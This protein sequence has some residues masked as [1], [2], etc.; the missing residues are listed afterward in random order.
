MTMRTA[1]AG[2]LVSLLAVSAA[3]AKPD[4]HAQARCIAAYE[5]AAGLLEADADAASGADKI[6]IRKRISKLD[7]NR[8][9]LSLA[10]ATRTDLTP[11]DSKASQ[12]ERKAEEARLDA[13]TP[14]AVQAIAD[15]CDP[16]AA[17]T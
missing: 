1:V 7:S 13:L 8:E 9:K 12:Q 5:V 17:A 2:L 6:A 15:A 11:A 16:I 4:F 14:T 3:Q 10:L